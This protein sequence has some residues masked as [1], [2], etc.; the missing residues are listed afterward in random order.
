MSLMKNSFLRMVLLKK[1]SS[2]SK[3]LEDFSKENEVILTCDTCDSLKNENA[4]LNEKVLDLTKIVHEF[5]N[6]KKF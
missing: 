5:T 4:S 1:K 3:E 6:G 2:L